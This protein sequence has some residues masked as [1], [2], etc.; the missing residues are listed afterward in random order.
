MKW[1][2]TW[3][4]SVVEVGFCVV[5]AVLQDVKKYLANNKASHADLGTK[6]F[7]IEAHGQSQRNG[8]RKAFLRAKREAFGRK[9]S[10]VFEVAVL[11]PRVN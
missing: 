11:F 2:W 4:A 6:L 3:I 1:K 5:L 7:G 9:K 10:I 8:Q